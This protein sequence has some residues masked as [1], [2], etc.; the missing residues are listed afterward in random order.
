MNQGLIRQGDVLI[1]LGWE[2]YLDMAQ[3]V[4]VQR[5]DVGTLYRLPPLP[6]ETE[7]LVMVRVT[8]ATAEPDGSFKDYV[9]R[10]P[11]ATKSATEAIAWTFDL[12]VKDYIVAAAS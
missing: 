6:N 12:P 11:P 8:N 2:R 1:R 5:D 7:D 4:P 10:V 3:A 9:L